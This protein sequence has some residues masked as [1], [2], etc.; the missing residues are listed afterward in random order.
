MQGEDEDVYSRLKE[1]PPDEEYEFDWLEPG[2]TARAMAALE[3]DTRL[4][5]SNFPA[6]VPLKKNNCECP[7]CPDENVFQAARTKLVPSKIRENDF[8]RNYFYK[9]DMIV[10]SY[11]KM[12]NDKR[13]KTTV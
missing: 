3:S 9:C 4:A 11:L 10:N 8:W 7:L 6:N 13:E 2:S 5:V 1:R 12:T